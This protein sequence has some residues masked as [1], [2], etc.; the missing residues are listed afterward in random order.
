MGLTVTVA[1][2][3]PSFDVEFLRLTAAQIIERSS[4]VG[5]LQIGLKLGRVRLRKYLADFGFGEATGFEMP[6]F[7]IT[8]SI[9]L[10]TP[11]R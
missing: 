4:N 6:I 10:A 5:I 3:H 9:P 8:F 1:R 7:A 11:L 2:R